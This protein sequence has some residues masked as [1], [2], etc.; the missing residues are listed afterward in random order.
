[1]VTANI[2]FYY[3]PRTFCL[4]DDLHNACKLKIHPHLLSKKFMA[5]LNYF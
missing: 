1:M 3:S 2:Y 4:I 5:T